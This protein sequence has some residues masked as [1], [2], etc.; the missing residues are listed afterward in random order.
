MEATA[1]VDRWQV[2]LESVFARVAGRFGRADLRRRMR[3]YVRGLLA[4]V[5]RKNGPRRGQPPGSWPNGPA[6]ATRPACSTC[7]TAPGRTPTRSGTTCATMSPDGSAPG[8]VLIIDDTGFVKKGTTSAGVGRQYTGTSGKI[9]NP[10]AGVPPARSGCPPPTPPARAGPWSTGNST[11]PGPGPPI[12]SGAGRRRSRTSGALR[13]R[14][15]RP[16]TSSTAAWRRDC[17]P[18]GS[19]RTRP[20]ASAAWTSTRSDAIRA[21]TGTSPSPCWPTRSSRPCPLPQ[22]R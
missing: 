7:S 18:P 3:D 13:P 9:D 22:R 15:N 11:Y 8:G 5:E 4:P 6:T 17:P 19:P 21:G 12:A 1:E 20:R 10:P 14:E 2:E 16:G